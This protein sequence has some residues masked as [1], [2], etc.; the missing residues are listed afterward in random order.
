VIA[1]LSILAGILYTAGPWPLG[2]IGLGELLV[3]IFFGP[4]AVGGTYYVQSLEINAAVILAGFAPGL[5]SVAILSVNNLRD[6]E[7]DRQT[8]KKTLAVR[9]GRPFAMAEYFFSVI[10]ACLIPIAVHVLTNNYTYSL[11]AVLTIFFTFPAFY[12]V[13]ARKHGRSLNSTLAYT[14]KLL[15]LYTILFSVGWIM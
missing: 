14:G 5:L 6:I 11:L 9:F 2:Y 3:L 12:I 15:F 10:G 7:E 8:G 4:V 1:F 13:F